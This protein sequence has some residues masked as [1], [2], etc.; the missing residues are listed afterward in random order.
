M[1]CQQLMRGQHTQRVTAQAFAAESVP[2]P[3]FDGALQNLLCIIRQLLHKAA[4]CG[5]AA[6]RVPA[7]SRNKAVDCA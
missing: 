1:G 2:N 6:G 4:Q 3:V 5:S 7:C